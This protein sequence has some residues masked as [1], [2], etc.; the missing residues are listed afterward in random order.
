M[1]LRRRSLSVIIL[2]DTTHVASLLGSGNLFW[3]LSPVTGRD[4]PPTPALDLAGS[5]LGP[6]FLSCL[7]KPGP[8]RCTPCVS[9]D[10]LKLMGPEMQWV[11]WGVVCGRPL[12]GRMHF[13]WDRWLQVRQGEG[14]G[15]G[16]GGW[17]EVQGLQGQLFSKRES[18]SQVGQQLIRDGQFLQQVQGWF[19]A[20]SGASRAPDIGVPITPAAALKGQLADRPQL[21][22]GGVGWCSWDPGCPP[23]FGLCNSS[24]PGL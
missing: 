20:G 8:A 4:V 1:N 7:S 5:L 18:R 17:H 11:P 21:I 15:Q 2:M 23:R 14:R 9:S 6:L 10:D 16:W 3:L 19:W 24:G 12:P 13:R 22:G